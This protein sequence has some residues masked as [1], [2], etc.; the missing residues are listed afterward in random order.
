MSLRRKLSTEEQK[1]A[2]QQRQREETA[3]KLREQVER[4]QTTFSLAAL[5][6]IAG[7]ARQVSIVESSMPTAVISSVLATE[8]GSDPEFVTAVILVSTLASSIT[9]SVLLTVVN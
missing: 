3:R 2:E 4:F 1:E 7:L 9:L 8:F 6:G 5:L